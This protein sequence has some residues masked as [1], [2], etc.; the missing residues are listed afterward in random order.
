MQISTREARK[1]CLIVVGVAQSGLGISAIII[2]YLLHFDLFDLRV[3][4]YTHASAEEFPPI[5]TLIVALFGFF[6]IISGI[7]LLTEREELGESEI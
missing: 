1:I 4:L 2:T 7:F 5:Y 6:S 3:R